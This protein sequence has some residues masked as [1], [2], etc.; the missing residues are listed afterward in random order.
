M[1][2]REEGLKTS[3]FGLLILIAAVIWFWILLR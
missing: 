1:E 2:D 3:D